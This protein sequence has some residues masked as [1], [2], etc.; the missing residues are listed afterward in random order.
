MSDGA[1]P[2]GLPNRPIATHQAYGQGTPGHG[3]A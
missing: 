3:R 1:P 2:W